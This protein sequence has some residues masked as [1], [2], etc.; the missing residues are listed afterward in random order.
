VDLSEREDA[1]LIELKGVCAAIAETVLAD[2]RSKVSKSRR[3]LS[4]TE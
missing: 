4:S 2:I 3:D 1:L